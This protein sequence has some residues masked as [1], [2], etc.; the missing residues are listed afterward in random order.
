MKRLFIAVLILVF[1]FPLLSIGQTEKPLRNHEIGLNFSGLNSFG[2]NYKTGKSNTM[3]RL[4]LLSL[5]LGLN[6]SWGRKEDSL[7]NKLTNC[8]VGIRL[9]FERRIPLVKSLYFLW[10][11]D[12][13]CSYSFGKNQQEGYVNDS[14]TTM[15]SVSPLVSLQIGA[16]Y[17][18]NDVLVISAEIN[19]SIV[20]TYG[21]VKYEQNTYSQEMTTSN[22][23]FGF[24]N[25]VA[26]I[27]IAY[28]FKK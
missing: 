5:N 25:T 12:G 14:K 24:T 21:V 23:S 26:S 4:S 8:G 13:G 1:C 20:Y 7:D 17:I 2:I 19:P 16:G 28:R 3:F 18:V 6:K 15:W 27:T 10:G 22:F 9:G 11:L